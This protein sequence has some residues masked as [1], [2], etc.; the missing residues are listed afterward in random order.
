MRFKKLVLSL[1]FLVGLTFALYSC[2]GDGGGSP[3]GGPGP[4]SPT[5]VFDP[6]KGIIP[7]P[8]DLL[9]AG[10]GGVLNLEALVESSKELT[11]VTPQEALYAAIDGLHLE[12][13]S[14]NTPIMFPLDKQTQLN[15]KELESAVRVIDLT[16][17]TELT[18]KNYLE[19]YY[20]QT[21]DPTCGAYLAQMSNENLAFACAGDVLGFYALHN[22]SE[23][24]NF[25]NTYYLAIFPEIT[26]KQV[27]SAIYAYPMI[28]FAPGHHF[29]AVLTDAVGNLLPS[30]LF[31]LLLGKQEL[32][33]NLAPLEPLRE[34]YQKLL[35]LLKLFSIN[36]DDI[37]SLTTFS[38]ADRTLSLTDYGFIQAALSGSISLDFLKNAVE[39]Y[40]YSS[41]WADNASNEYL[42]M[43]DP[44]SDIPLVCQTY[45][46]TATS[47]DLTF[48]DN[49]FK[50]FNVYE[51]TKIA[52]IAYDLKNKLGSDNVSGVIVDCQKLF[53][54]AT[55]YV[56]VPYKVYNNS[57][58]HPL[59]ILMYQHGLGRNKS[60]AGALAST[61][62]NYEIFSMDLP[63][64]GSRVLPYDDPSTACHENVSGSCYL[65]SNPINDVLNIYQSI[66]DMHVFLKF[67]YAGDVNAV[68]K[69]IEAQPSIEPYA[70]P[71]P[72]Y[73]TGQSMGSITGSMLL[74]VDNITDS[75]ALSGLKLK[76]KSQLPDFAGKLKSENL[77]DKAVLNVGGAN[78]SAIL[79]EATN[80]EILALICGVL[81]I[82]DEQCRVQTVNSLKNTV[83]YNLT[84]AIFQLL[85]D[86]VDP[87]NFARNQ[88]LQPKVVYQSANH[89]TLV[90]FTSNKIL[91]YTVGDGLSGVVSDST[92]PTDDII[93][94]P[95]AGWYMFG[96]DADGSKAW[97]NH[98]FLIHTAAT[99]SELEDMYPSAAGHLSL[100]YVNKMEGLCRLQAAGFLKP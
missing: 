90:P 54:N 6:T 86:P 1:I 57:L 82:P 9:L 29:V 21:Q 15:P 67:I 17:L 77:I 26:V 30:S 20:S 41:L 40:K 97:V 7:F 74:N 5:V 36:K 8:N 66:L 58:T 75:A 81:N 73:Y 93:S 71:L 34:E 42:Y 72:V 65:T 98:G 46:K 70:Q 27:G 47:S 32:T 79:N 83:K 48:F 84:I 91:A 37:L 44:L 94:N 53:D 13:F 95:A 92:E 49:Y 2:G 43:I 39:G 64:H 23:L 52:P 24:L 85:L 35:A 89:D 10:T 11:T 50:D 14:P 4:T 28:H 78:Y 31:E 100:D 99:L 12:G 19:S 60:D 69:Y 22:Q 56:K 87:T 62:S 51:L 88:G 3:S 18:L 61:F 59:G 33:G 25:I 68:V 63:W 96:S 76:L 55:L 80:P 38:T 16:A 45:Y